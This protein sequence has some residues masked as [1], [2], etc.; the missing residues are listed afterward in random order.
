MEYE[1]IISCV[2]SIMLWIGMLWNGTLDIW[3][4]KISLIPVILMILIGIS[5]RFLQGELGEPWVWYGF[6]PG[7]GC[8]FLSFVTKGE[9]GMGDGWML[10]GMGALIEY[11]LLYCSCVFAM[12]FAAIAAGVLIVIFRKNRKYS[13]PFV[14]F[15]TVGYLCARYLL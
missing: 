6:L 1:Q 8:M 7:V 4:K 13:I 10:L 14:P 2:I 3:K 11:E 12:L 9:I 5:I 15:L